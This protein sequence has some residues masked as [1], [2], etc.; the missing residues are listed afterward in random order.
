MM[1]LVEVLPGFPSSIHDTVRSQLTGGPLTLRD[2]VSN[3][4][5]KD[6]IISAARVADFRPN[7][8][9]RQPSMP[10]FRITS[11]RNLNP[12]QDHIQGGRFN[13]LVPLWMLQLGG[14]LPPR[15]LH[16]MLRAPPLATRSGSAGS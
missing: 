13:L 16:V 7:S 11:S 9:L 5:L 8:I 15:P 6:K 14:L 10:R 4:R 3:D 2:F 1:R 12:I